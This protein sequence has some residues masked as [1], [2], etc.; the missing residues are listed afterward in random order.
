MCLHMFTNAW[1]TGSDKIKDT[2]NYPSMSL[3]VPFN[4]VFDQTSAPSLTD[5][6]D[7]N[8]PMRKCKAEKRFKQKSAKTKNENISIE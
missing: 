8:G 5:I 4:N 3:R 2:T 1:F 7:I 6:L